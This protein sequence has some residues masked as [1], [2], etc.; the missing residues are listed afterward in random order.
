MSH[1]FF[2]LSIKTDHHPSPS[3]PSLRTIRTRSKL[4]SIFKNFD[5]VRRSHRQN[6]SLLFLSSSVESVEWNC[7]KRRKICDYFVRSRFSGYERGEKKSPLSP[8]GHFFD[9]FGRRCLV[10]SPTL[11]SWFAAARAINYNPCPSLL[12]PLTFFLSFFS[13][14]FTIEPRIMWGENLMAS[15]TSPARNSWPVEERTNQAARNIDQEPR[16]VAVHSWKS[17]SRTPLPSLRFSKFQ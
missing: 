4:L 16:N 5:S 8:R 15:R 12:L 9:P 6:S 11:T 14:N 7:S 13:Q 3:F 10:V 2:N 1:P 17:T